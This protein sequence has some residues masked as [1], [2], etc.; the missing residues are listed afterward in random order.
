MRFRSGFVVGVAVGYVLGT[1]AGRRR[2]EQLKRLYQASRKH[3]AI[4]QLVDQAQGVTD[5]GRSVMATGLDVGSR[6]LRK[7]G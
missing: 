2:Y 6:R 1:R 7:L 5:L 3:P 4:A